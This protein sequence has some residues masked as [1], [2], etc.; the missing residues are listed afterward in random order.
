MVMTVY[1]TN[2]C[3]ILTYTLVTYVY[4]YIAKFIRE[5]TVLFATMATTWCIPQGGRNH[6]QYADITNQVL[7]F[8]IDKY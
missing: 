4:L 1:E 3:M 5:N 2:V 8:I 7:Q 6:L